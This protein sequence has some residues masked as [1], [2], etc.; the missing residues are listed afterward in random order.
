MLSPRGRSGGLVRVF[1]ARVNRHDDVAVPGLEPLRA[2]PGVHVAAKQD[3]EHIGRL[4]ARAR[5]TDDLRVMDPELCQLAAERSV[6]EELALIL[7]RLPERI[8]VR[9]ELR[10][11][12]EERPLEMGVATAVLHPLD[13]P[14]LVD[15]GP[16]GAKVLAHVLDPDHLDAT[17]ESPSKLGH[18][19]APHGRLV[20]VELGGHEAELACG[21]QFAA[22]HVLR[23]AHAVV[24]HA[25]TLHL[26]QMPE[27]V[28]A[29]AGVALVAQHDGGRYLHAADIEGFEAHALPFL[30]CADEDF[31][32]EPN[33]DTRILA[34]EVDDGADSLISVDDVRRSA[35]S[36]SLCY[37]VLPV[38]VAAHAEFDVRERFP[39]PESFEDA[40][41]LTNG[42][43]LALIVVDQQVREGSE[44]DNT[45]KNDLFPV[46]VESRAFNG[47]GLIAFGVHCPVL[48]GG[49]GL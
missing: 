44:G 5:E 11:D 26:G 45:P 13:A 2:L 1:S 20:S 21:D 12:G 14:T 43:L 30:R 22:S 8:V 9:E 35:Q 17:V 3:V 28:G 27:H 16:E 37:L 7:V 29:G 31:G 23:P 39:L 18:V 32:A 38:A 6:D 41:P 10:Q 48:L 4:A 24:H 15:E 25:R 42:Q 36:G 19:A 46:D 49:F 33:H 40:R 47:D 34:Q